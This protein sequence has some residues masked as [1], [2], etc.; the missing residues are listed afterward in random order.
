MKEKRELINWFGLLGVVSLLSYIAAVVFSPLAYPNYNW[1]SQA[2]SDL[3]AVNAP[4]KALWNQLSS[5]YGVC[6]MISVMMVCVAVQKKTN[7]VVRIGIYLFTAMNGISCVGYT[8][9]PLTSSGYAGTFQDIMHVYVVTFFVVVLSISSLVLI[10]VGGYR[11]KSFLSL[12]LWATI[13]LAFMFMGAMGINIVPVEY[14]GIPERF[15]VFSA[16]GFNAVLG[17]YLFL[18]KF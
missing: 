11:K 8:L 13:A 12:A 3:S 7:K 16:T 6:G 15:S 5:L 10:M 18:N 14:F 17:V 2:V 9:F 1:I 4:S